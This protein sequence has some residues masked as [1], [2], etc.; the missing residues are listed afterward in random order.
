MDW[1]H[2]L[3][4]AIILVIGYWLGSKYPGMLNKVTAGTVSG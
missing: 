2:Y 1:R 3:G 4:I